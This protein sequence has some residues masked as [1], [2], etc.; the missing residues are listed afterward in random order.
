MTQRR[1][2]SRRPQSR[3]TQTKGRPQAPR[4]RS[5]TGWI[6]GGVV[7]AVVLIGFIIATVSTGGSGATEVAD[8]TVT[9]EA[10]PPLPES[11]PDPAIGLPMPDFAGVSFDD[12]PV[13][14]GNDGRAKVLLVLTHW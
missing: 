2:P 7:A 1:N 10:L 13:S 6:I 14:I 11:G 3:S 5:T 8:V 9:G 4:R 12:T